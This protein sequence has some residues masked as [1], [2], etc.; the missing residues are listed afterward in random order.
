MAEPKAEEPDPFELAAD[1]A[2]AL[3]DG[4][5]RAALRAALVANAFYEQDVE[6]LARLISAGYTRRRV[7]PARSASRKQ[8]DWREISGGQ[9]P[10][11][12]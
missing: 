2:I 11:P 3:C 7:S 5:V 4:D 10:K 1:Q 6:R 9:Q 12:E 8:D